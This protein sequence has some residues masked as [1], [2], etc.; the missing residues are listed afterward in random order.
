M[1][2]MALAF[3]RRSRP[4]SSAENGTDCVLEVIADGKELE[5]GV[6]FELKENRLLWVG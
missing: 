4:E 6:D 2:K 3:R 1:S 5:S